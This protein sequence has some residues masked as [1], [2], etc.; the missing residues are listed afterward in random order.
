MNVA[1]VFP[2]SIDADYE[3]FYNYPTV[4]AAFGS[5]DLN[6]AVAGNLQEKGGRGVPPPDFMAAGNICG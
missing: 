2:P 1:R 3:T 5:V 4:P 6:L